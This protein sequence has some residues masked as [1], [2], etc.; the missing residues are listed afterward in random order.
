MSQLN[1]NKIINRT[2]TGGPVL[3][4]LSTVSG[5]LEVSSNLDVTGNTTVSG[6]LGSVGIVTATGAVISGTATCTTL[7]ATGDITLSAGNS[8]TVGDTFIQQ[9][10]VGLGTTT[11]AGRTGIANTAA[12]TLVYNAQTSKVEVYDG[13]QWVA[14]L[15]SPTGQIEATGGTIVTDATHR[16]HIF[17]GTGAFAVSS[18]PPTATVEYLVVAGGGSG[19]GNGNTGGAG[20]AGGL[21]TGSSHPIQ[22][23]AYVAIVAGAGQLGAM[24]NDSQFVLTG[25]STITATGGGHRGTDGGSGNGSG[26]SGAGGGANNNQPAGVTISSPDGISPTAQGNPGGTGGGSTGRGA[27]GGGGAGGAGN[28]GTPSVGGD[29]GV[30]TPISWIPTDYGTPGPNPGRYFGGGGGGGKDGP[31]GTGG[32]G[33]AGGGGKGQDATTDNATAGAVNTGGGG[34]GGGG[35]TGVLSGTAKAGGSGF[36]AIRYPYSS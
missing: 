3:T 33:G 14:G 20:G 18:C 4:G 36:V 12:G 34:G 23:A 26:G 19:F 6:N 5:S 25:V 28:P 29:G 32:A 11:T 22:A 8:I 1:V 24:G 30:G 15:A 35:Q 9:N 17:T 27:G 2:G 21:R 10:S 16:T 13:T 7:S 31:G